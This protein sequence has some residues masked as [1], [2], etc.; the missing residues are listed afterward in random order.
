MTV[1]NKESGADVHEFVDRV[2]R[3][4]TAAS[5]QLTLCIPS[6]SPSVSMEIGP[7]NETEDAGVCEVA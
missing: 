5:T 2:F 7:V 3:I 1:T 4:S 6:V